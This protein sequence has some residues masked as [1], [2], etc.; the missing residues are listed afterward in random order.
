MGPNEINEKTIPKMFVISPL[1]TSNT[2]ISK[3]IN[4]VSIEAATKDNIKKSKTPA[5]IFTINIVKRKSI[6]KL[7]SIS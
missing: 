1:G 2:R 6:T 5:I 7:L 3:K 4:R